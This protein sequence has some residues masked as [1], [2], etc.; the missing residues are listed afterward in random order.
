MNFVSM[1]KSLAGSREK[2]M[3]R[4][5]FFGGTPCFNRRPTVFRAGLGEIVRLSVPV[6]TG[7]RRAQGNDLGV[8]WIVKAAGFSRRV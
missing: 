6:Q 1:A 7:L 2:K 3:A 8:A 5:D 4:S